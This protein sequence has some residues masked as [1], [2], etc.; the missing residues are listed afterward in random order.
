MLR[1]FLAGYVGGADA[2]Q[3][4]EGRR[5]PPLGAAAATARARGTAPGPGQFLAYLDHGGSKP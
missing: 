2:V 3:I 5:C 4:T 1:N